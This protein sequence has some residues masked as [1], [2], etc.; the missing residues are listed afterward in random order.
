MAFTERE[1]Y[2]E[3]YTD[4]YEE[5]LISVT[6]KGYGCMVGNDCR[7]GI[8]FNGPWWKQWLLEELR[9]LDDPWNDD[10]DKEEN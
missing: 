8:G 2:F 3:F 10:W 5:R 6:Y 4:F 1:P 9:D 7:P